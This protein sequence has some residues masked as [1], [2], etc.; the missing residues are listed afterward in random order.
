MYPYGWLV[1]AAA[2]RSAA[3]CASAGNPV[4][5]HPESMAA[6]VLAAP[7]A[8]SCYGFALA[9]YYPLPPAVYWARARA[10]CGWRMVSM[11]TTKP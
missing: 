2:V 6:L 4:S 5:V 1:P 7:F 8:A 10:C 9:R 11:P 3:R